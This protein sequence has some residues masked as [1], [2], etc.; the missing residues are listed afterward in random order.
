MFEIHIIETLVHNSTL[1]LTQADASH[2]FVAAT[3]TTVNIEM[4]L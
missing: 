3:P 4:E 1:A 2:I